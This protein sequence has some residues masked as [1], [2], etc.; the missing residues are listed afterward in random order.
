VRDVKEK[1]S[2]KKQRLESLVASPLIGGKE[3]YITSC[4]DQ[5]SPD[6]KAQEALE[7]P[8]KLNQNGKKAIHRSMEE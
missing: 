3:R 8:N 2:E 6:N 7:F 1:K 5:R 4:W